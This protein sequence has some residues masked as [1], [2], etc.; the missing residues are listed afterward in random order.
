MWGRI[1]SHFHSVRVDPLGFVSSGAK[2]KAAS[3]PMDSFSVPTRPGKP[4]KPGKMRV[5]L[6]NLEISWNFKKFNK[7]HGK[8]T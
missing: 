4:G 7:Y 6:E 2:T 1:R 5:H 3:L 8:M